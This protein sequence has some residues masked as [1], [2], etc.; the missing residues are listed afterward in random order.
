M[1]IRYWIIICVVL[2]GGLGL[3]ARFQA[4]GRP[5]STDSPKPEAT[6][7]PHEMKENEDHD[8]DNEEEKNGHKTGDKDEHGEADEDHEDHGDH[9]ESEEESVGGVGKGNAVTAANKN[10][11]IRLSPKAI[12][13]MGIKTDSYKNGIIPASA[14]VRYQDNLGVYRLRE[15]WFKLIPIT[16]K[17]QQGDSLNIL[18]PDLETSDQIAVT[19]TGLLRA[20]ELDA[21]SGEAAH[22]H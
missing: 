19:G 7:H 11:G 17:N 16:I 5:S 2:L 1:K 12:E 10:R 20:A 3:Q 18:S 9:G 6:R 21:F 15:N 14:L 8:H 4:K 22:S 13:T